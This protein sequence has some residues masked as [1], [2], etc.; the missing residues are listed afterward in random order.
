[1]FCHENHPIHHF[2]SIHQDIPLLRRISG[3][4]KAL[5]GQ[6][7]ASVLTW[8]IILSFH[9]RLVLPQGIFFPKIRIDFKYG[10]EP[11]RSTP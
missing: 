8:K 9:P 7:T 4:T 6:G 11:R 2:G 1:M 5:Q 10:M 3:N